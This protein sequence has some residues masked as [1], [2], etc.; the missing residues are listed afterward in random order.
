MNRLQVSSRSESSNAVPPALQ[1]APSLGAYKIQE[2]TTEGWLQL[3]CAT[4]STRA[5]LFACSRVRTAPEFS[6]FV[7]LR[8]TDAQRRLAAHALP[9]PVVRNSQQVSSMPS[10]VVDRKTTPRTPA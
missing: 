9:C 2:E 1:L 4:P 3:R 8:P 7:Y 5:L 10:V 6:L